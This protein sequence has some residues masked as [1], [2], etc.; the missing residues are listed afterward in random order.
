MNRHFFR[1]LLLCLI[2]AV[3][4]GAVGF[5][6]TGN[7]PRLALQY[8]RAGDSPDWPVLRD[9]PVWVDGH[10]ENS[11][12]G[13]W[14]DFNGDGE[15]DGWVS[16]AYWVDGTWQSVWVE[17]DPL[18]DGVFGSS[19]ATDAGTFNINSAS[20]TWS[21]AGTWH[22]GGYTRGNLLF[23]FE[24]YDIITFR[25]WGLAPANNCNFYSYGVYRPDGSLETG[26]SGVGWS[27][28]GGS[29]MMDGWFFADQYGV[30][31]IEVRYHNATGV[32]PEA[33]TVSYYL[34]V[35][36]ALTQT[37]TFDPIPT[38]AFGDAPFALPAMAE[39]GLPVVLS[40]ISGP[41]TLSG[42]II[43]LTGNGAVTVRAAQPGGMV[44]G[45]FWNAAPPVDR[46]F[47]VIGIAQ[48]ITFDALPGRTQ[49]DPPFALTATASSGLQVTFSVTAGPA[50]ISGNVVSLTG[51]GTVVITSAQNGGG[52]YGPALKVS[53]S[54][55]VSPVPPPEITSANAVETRVG[56]D[57]IYEFTFSRPVT[58]LGW[59]AASVPPGLQFVETVPNVWTRITGRPTVPGIYSYTVTASGPSGT[60][61][62]FPFVI[63]V[64]TSSGLSV[65]TIFLHPLSQTVAAGANLSFTVGASGASA[66][67]WY[68]DGNPLPTEQFPVLYINGASAAH[69]GTYTVVVRNGAG[70]VTSNP[71]TLTVIGTGGGALAGL[72]V[73][74][75]QP[76]GKAVRPGS[77]VV[78]FVDGT[79]AIPTTF[80]WRKDGIALGGRTATDLPI[81]GFS[82]VDVG[83]FD[84]V[85]T[86]ATGSVT[87]ETAALSLDEYAQEIR[88]LPLPN[89]AFPVFD[90]TTTI[91]LKAV[92]T[93][94]LPVT[95]SVVS[96]P[97]TVA[98]SVLTVTGA[99]LITVRAHQA[100]AQNG[101]TGTYSA[102]SLDREF[103]VV[104]GTP[105]P[106]P[107]ATVA[108]SRVDPKRGRAVAAITAAPPKTLWRDLDGDGIPEEI[109]PAGVNDFRVSFDV[110]QLL[111]LAFGW[112]LLEEKYRWVPVFLGTYFDP[113]ADGGLGATV[114]EYDFV[115][116]PD[117]SASV[118][119]VVEEPT[120]DI[121]YTFLVHPGYEY[122]RFGEFNHRYGDNIERWPMT[123]MRPEVR[124]TS[125][126]TGGVSAHLTIADFNQP[127]VF[128]STPY[129]VIRKGK[130][131]AAA[132]L[133]IG[134]KSV[135][136]GISGSSVGSITLPLP[137]G[138]SV[139]VKA[140]AGT[141]SVT[142]G[143]TTVSVGAGGAVTVNG[144]PIGGGTVDLGSGVTGAADS[145]GVTL[146]IPEVGGILGTTVHVNPDGSG[147]IVLSNGAGIAVSR[148]GQVSLKLPA[149]TPQILMGAV[150]ILGKVL[151]GGKGAGVSV[152][153]VLGIIG[154]AGVK[155]PM[156]NGVLDDID[157]RIRSGGS[158][159]IGIKQSND[160]FFWIAV[161]MPIPARLL[162]DANRDSTITVDGADGTTVGA[163]YRFW[164]NDD[165]DALVN[166][167][168]ST[169]ADNL[170]PPGYLSPGVIIPPITTETEEDDK[171]V[172]NPQQEDWRDNIIDT[173]RDLEDFTRLQLSIGGLQD[174]FKNGQ[175][176][177][178]LKWADTNGTSPAI[179][180]YRATDPNGS[181]SYLFNPSAASSQFLQAAIIDAR[182]P[183]YNLGQGSFASDHTLIGGADVFI[184]PTL[185]LGALSATNSTIPFIFEGCTAGKGQLKLII[186]KKDGTN[187]TEIGEGPGVWLE[188]KKPNEYVERFSCGDNHLGNVV[189]VS[190]TSTSATFAAPTK[191]EEKDYVLYVHGYNMAEF[192]K[193][194]WIETAYK[195]LWHLGYKGRVGGFSWPCSQS[196]PPF[197]ASEEKAWQSAEQ[198]K[199]HLANLKAQGYRVHVI[200][201][202][203]GN[204]VTA[205]ALRQSGAG[206]AA[207]R[208]YIASQAAVAASCYK[209]NVPLM[210]NPGQETPD[211]YGTYP[212]T[213]L[214]YFDGSAMS[215]A[216]S[217]YVNFYNPIDYAL[218]SAS[219]NGFSWETDQRL[220]PNQGWG[221]N[222]VDGF[223]ESN[224]SGG[225]TSRT[226]PN[227]RFRIFSYGAEAK[228]LA[229]GALPTGGVFTS[230]TNL[231]TTQQYGPEH[232]YHSGQFR[233]SLAIR[234][235]YW[236]A[237]L[238]AALIPRITP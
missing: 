49:T 20:S 147:S 15:E 180:L 127:L 137:A 118:Y 68:K 57:F 112:D 103:T 209:E 80:Q 116:V 50:I 64:K 7:S 195:R 119:A 98:G 28:P 34:T 19:W 71:A 185:Q 22:S 29:A 214:P 92:A 176:H 226:L 190:R 141:G 59:S 189:A 83:F 55:P 196:A 30:W 227:D 43:T 44:S 161:T 232:I 87:S 21:S 168:W 179:K 6:Q 233:A 128:A 2:A 217:R 154:A 184:I 159:E 150:D 124:H 222:I 51:A 199:T 123:I 201:H 73:I 1:P 228:S 113:S 212:P 140:G 142:I 234:Y 114:S 166:Y 136:I 165:D 110:Q 84:V 191:D 171:N 172:T 75:R 32:S 145:T 12:Q 225:L 215:G 204:V 144:S 135:G 120:V 138:G 182:Y 213:S 24:Y 90:A 134:G 47:S 74:T 177:L 221:Y 3:C 229:L 192:E 69:V 76:Q 42:N 151:Q 97:A 101:P 23:P 132:T 223:F 105:P 111:D 169:T 11:G 156:P 67:Q 37:I 194:R 133:S 160:Q 152:R 86:N 187:Y 89:R 58:V 31:R 54:F 158:F 188:I 25:A 181:N 237:L 235:Q 96:G 210:P 117:F 66:Y 16:E 35:G 130:P 107:G 146:S 40:V 99:G 18:P 211:I 131:F 125:A 102:A 193:Q 224:I 198:L 220:K 104:Q 170:L 100:G 60:S 230:F 236:M 163:P 164:L 8:W 61:P 56:E 9:E 207:V 219:G 39:S 27:F 218:T 238:D 4:L 72:P 36:P 82:A 5:G 162:V 121:F 53:R 78:L 109:T 126:E 175:L 167:T 129:Y 94:L 155:Y 205:E 143:G 200:A 231:Q 79:S 63:N 157:V 14:E 26:N 186:L 52:V 17:G 197:D 48:T 10:E 203:Q 93:S 122:F 33:G 173:P 178:G 91:T 85:V 46:T 108:A 174:A 13:H 81:L 38:H 149:G 183:G 95:F 70:S 216:A 202:S 41:A 88:F 77:N 115:Q 106:L 148:S 208:T 45:T 206:S 65:P 139:T 153:D 62:P